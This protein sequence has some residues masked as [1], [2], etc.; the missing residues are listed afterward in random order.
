[1]GAGFFSWGHRQVPPCVSHVSGVRVDFV[2][3][4]LRVLHWVTCTQVRAGGV[5]LSG[6][7]LRAAKVHWLT[8]QA[9]L[10]PLG[11]VEKCNVCW[12]VSWGRM[13][14]LRWR[15]EGHS[16]Q[17]RCDAIDANA[18]PVSVEGGRGWLR[19]VTCGVHEG[20][21]CVCVLCACDSRSGCVFVYLLPFHGIR[22]FDVVS[23]SFRSFPRTRKL[24][25][26]R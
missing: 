6:A 5:L 8:C 15:K 22:S 18:T 24:C 4:L 20:S 12:V 14:I 3:C 11:W 16:L 21:V 7:R 25:G 9:L 2:R 1:M 26:V 17:M 23:G 19:S 13:R 10:F